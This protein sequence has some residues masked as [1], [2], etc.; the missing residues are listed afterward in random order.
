MITLTREPSASRASA[1]GLSSST[2]R[3]SGARIRSIASRRARSDVEPH[4]GALDPPAAL[5]VDVVGPVDHH[6]LDRRVGEQLLERPKADRVAQDQLPDLL[7]P[8]P[9][10]ATAACS[11][12]SSATAAS[13]S[14]PLGRPGGG[15]G[16]PALQQAAAKVGGQRLGVTFD[17]P[18]DRV[19]PR[20][21]GDAPRMRSGRA[22][23]R[24]TLPAMAEIEVRQADITKLEVDAIAN[25]AQY[26]PAARRRRRRRDRPRRRSEHPGRERR[27]SPRSSSAKRW[28]PAAGELPVQAGSST[29]RRWSS[30]APRRPRPSAPRHREHPARRPMSSAPA[31]SALVAFGTGVGGFPIDDAARHRGRGGPP[32][33][34]GGQRPGADRVRRLRRGRPARLRRRAALWADQASSPRAVSAGSAAPA[35]RSSRPGSAGAPAASGEGERRVR[36]S[37]RGPGPV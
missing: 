8:A 9:P 6:L 18:H 13:S 3:P 23:D 21:A 5:D 20:A 1:I 14:S 7:A 30:A 34:G 11:S 33:S 26:R 17:D 15:L 27:A 4:L 25:A 37:S 12:T 22:R 28:R 31:P 10:R 2:R 36:G 19:N 35:G 32:A 29:P 24:A 16:A